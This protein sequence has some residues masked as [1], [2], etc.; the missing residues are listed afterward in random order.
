VN[1]PDAQIVEV[2]NQLRTAMLGSDV[3]ALD[4]LLAPDLIFTNHLGQLLGKDDDLAAFGLCGETLTGAA[5]FTAAGIP[6][7]FFTRMEILRFD[8]SYGFAFTRNS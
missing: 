5:P 3:T 4:D 1:S 8:G 2:E 6:S 7:W